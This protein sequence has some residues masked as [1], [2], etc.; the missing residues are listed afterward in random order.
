[1]LLPITDYCSM[2]CSHCMSSCTTEGKHIT[3]E[4]FIKNLDY[5]YSVVE[6]SVNHSIIISGGEPF[7]HPQIR[8][9]LR[10]IGNYAKKHP[11]VLVYVATNGFSLANNPS[12][13]NEYRNYVKQFRN[14]FTQIVNYPEFYPKNLSEKNVYHLSKIQRSL[15]ATDASEMFLYPQGRALSLPNPQWRIGGG[16]KCSNIRLLAN[17][18]NTTSFKKVILNLPFLQNCLPRIN[19][20]GSISLGESLQCPSIGTIDDD[21]RG[22]YEAVKNCRCSSCKIACEHMK[23]TNPIAYSLILG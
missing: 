20:D 12:L 13:L 11:T 1:M 2:G 8:D 10:I 15:V 7:E 22:L 6:R 3:T 9:I 4:Q 23:K 19:I 5:A 16:P 14:I 18:L 21:D 17:Q